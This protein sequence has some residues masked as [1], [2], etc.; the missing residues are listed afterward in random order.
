MEESPEKAAAR[1]LKEE[2][3]IRDAYLEQLYTYGDA[4]A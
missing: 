1:E 4:R 3:G 2:T